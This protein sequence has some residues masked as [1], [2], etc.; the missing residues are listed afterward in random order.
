MLVITLPDIAD[1]HLAAA[2][3]YEIKTYTDS[4]AIAG[5]EKTKNTLLYIPEPTDSIITGNEANAS[6]I[7][8]NGSDI[9]DLSK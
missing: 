3:T 5:F 7:I 4:G 2:P 6:K 9:L 8:I 1:I